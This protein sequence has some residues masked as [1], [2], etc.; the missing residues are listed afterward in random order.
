M[1]AL[2]KS[3]SKIQQIHENSVKLGLTNIEPHVFD[4]TKACLSIVSPFEREKTKN[5]SLL[6]TPPFR[7]CS[8]D[9]I[10]LDAPCSALGQR[11]QLHNPIRLKE[12]L[13]FAG[14]QKK[15][16]STVCVTK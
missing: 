15:L 16:F 12:V 3:T 2:D 6:L 7:P 4:S 1:I 13:S 11:P 10:L 8:F 9:R 5:G 14:L